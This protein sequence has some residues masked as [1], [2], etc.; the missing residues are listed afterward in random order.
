M[1]KTKTKN[2]YIALRF[3]GRDD[4]HMVLRYFPN[5]TG[6]EKSELV[7]IVKYFVARAMLM[8]TFKKFRAK[9]EIE[10]WFGPQHT[11]RVLEPKSNHEWP[12]W[13]LALLA[14][15]PKGSDKYGFCPHVICKDDVLDV[16]VVSV[17]LMTKKVE[18]YRWNLQ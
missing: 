18:V 4:L 5:Q 15:L 1:A 16:Q 3:E 12:N 17:S 10:A 9:F 6:E 8:N 7:V 13:L 2:Y 11:V 14:K